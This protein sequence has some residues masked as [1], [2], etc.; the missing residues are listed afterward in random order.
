MSERLRGKVKF[1][2][3]RKGFGFIVR[4]DG[5]KDIFLHANNLPEGLEKINAEQLVTFE[6]EAHARGDRARNVS[7]A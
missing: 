2:N 6:V 1:F 3:E 5:A 4:D 7:L